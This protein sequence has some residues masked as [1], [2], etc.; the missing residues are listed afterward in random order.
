[1]KLTAQEAAVLAFLS[2][3][4]MHTEPIDIDQW[5]ELPPSTPTLPALWR[6]IGLGLVEREGEHCIAI[7]EAGREALRRLFE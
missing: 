6:L 5:L 7:T 4:G 2:A 1:M 3:S